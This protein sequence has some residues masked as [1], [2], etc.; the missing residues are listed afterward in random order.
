MSIKGNSRTLSMSSIS[1]HHKS[2]S[3]INSPSTIS[4][5]SSDKNK[6]FN[7]VNNKKIRSITSESIEQSIKT[8][9]NCNIAKSLNNKNTNKNLIDSVF[10]DEFIDDKDFQINNSPIS[11]DNYDCD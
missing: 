4:K 9:N 6:L 8:D 10:S 1:S 11:F 3:L 7:K 5:D 2:N